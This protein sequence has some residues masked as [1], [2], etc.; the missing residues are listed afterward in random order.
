MV[1]NAWHFTI[2]QLLIRD[3][4]IIHLLTTIKSQVEF[5]WSISKGPPSPQNQHM[6]PLIEEKYFYCYKNKNKINSN[7]YKLWLNLTFLGNVSSYKKFLRPPPP[8]SKI[9]AFWKLRIY[10][11]ILIWILLNALFFRWNILVLQEKSFIEIDSDFKHY[12]V[13]TLHQDLNIVWILK[14]HI[15]CLTLQIPSKNCIIKKSDPL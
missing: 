14:N 13:S 9:V 7:I 5:V 3:G 1:K 10:R 15:L 8:L 12:G 2:S 4:S 6:T 11:C